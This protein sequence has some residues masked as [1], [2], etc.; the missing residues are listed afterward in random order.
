[1]KLLPAILLAALVAG[2]AGP[3][4]TKAALEKP[5]DL[6]AGWTWHEVDGE[7]CGFAVPDDWKVMTTKDA[8]DLTPNVNGTMHQIVRS[9]ATSALLYSKETRDH[10]SLCQAA[11][12]VAAAVMVTHRMENETVD[13]DNAAAKAASQIAAAPMKSG[14]VSPTASSIDLPAGKAKLVSG[15]YSGANSGQPDLKLT[16]KRYIFGH[17]ADRYDVQVIGTSVS[18]SPE[19]DAEGIAKTFRFVK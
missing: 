19:A 14:D 15:E 10:G 8:E 1:M 5:T 16:V 7:G 17:G 9:M 11:D 6:P 4:A 2:C 3:S 18:G 13:L 12:P